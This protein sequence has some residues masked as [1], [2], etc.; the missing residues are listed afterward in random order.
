MRHGWNDHGSKLSTSIYIYIGTYIHIDIYI[1]MYTCII[2]STWMDLVS[3][4]G[5]R[6]GSVGLPWKNPR[7]NPRFSHGLARWAPLVSARSAPFFD[8]SMAGEKHIMCVYIYI[9]VDLHYFLL[10]SI[11]VLSYIVI[12][13]HMIMDYH[14]HIRCDHMCHPTLRFFGDVH[15]GN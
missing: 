6:C 4:H 9:W 12:Y 13:H 3:T 15:D 2:Y 7:K 11:C 14:I 8:N 5:K 10:F 1:Y